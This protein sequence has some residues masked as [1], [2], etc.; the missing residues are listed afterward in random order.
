VFVLLFSAHIGGVRFKEH[1]FAAQRTKR[2]IIHRRAD[3][4]SKEPSGFHAALKH[5]LNLASR[6]ALLARAHQMDGLQPEV[7]LQVRGLK[8]GPHAHGERLSARVALAQARAGSLAVQ[9]ANVFLGRA[10]KRASRTIGPKLRFDVSER[11]GFVLEMSGGKNRL[12]HWKSPMAKTL[13]HGVRYVKCNVSPRKQGRKRN[14][15]GGGWGPT[16]SVS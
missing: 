14:N 5:P 16:I 12:G 6:N 11:C 13:D 7:Q 2:A 8:D 4:V 3:A 10:A 15:R 9:P 1:A